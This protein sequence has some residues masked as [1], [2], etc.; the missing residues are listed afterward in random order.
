[1][2]TSKLGERNY[3]FNKKH[4]KET[5]EKM[6]LSHSKPILVTNIINSKVYLYPS[7]KQAALELNTYSTNIR[8]HLEKK[9]VMF[10]L[11][12]ITIPSKY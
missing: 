2:S 3:M 6:K 5:R 7:I 11:Y 12:I 10:N 1:M 4:T 8:R 9:T